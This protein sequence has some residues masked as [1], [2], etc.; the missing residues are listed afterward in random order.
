M[1]P[2]ATTRRRLAA[3]G[4]A[5]ALVAG[6]SSASP[7]HATTWKQVY[8]NGAFQVSM[9]RTSPIWIKT[10]VHNSGPFY[11]NYVVLS[12]TSPDAN[13]VHDL[14][15]GATKLIRNDITMT[16]GVQPVG[17]SYIDYFG[18]RTTVTAGY[19]RMSVSALPWC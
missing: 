16:D 12:T 8:S 9:C 19:F 17:W 2:C 18:T 7:A 3:L 15:V 4:G 5:L 14:L 1:F 6:V 13:S 11:I 10:K